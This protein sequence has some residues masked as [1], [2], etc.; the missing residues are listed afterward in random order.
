M[1]RKVDLVMF[2]APGAGKGTHAEILSK[3]YG[4]C[5]ISTGCLLRKEV[6]SGS[7]MGQKIQHIMDSGALVEDDL[8]LE[9]IGR[10]V[11]KDYNGMIFD[12]FP[13]T[14]AQ[15]KKLDELLDH[16]GRHLDVA[17]ALDV[18]QDELVRRMLER[19]TIEQRSDDNEHT[20]KRRQEEYA[21]HTL[22]VLKYY[23]DRGLLVHV[24]A[25]GDKETTQQRIAKAV[26]DAW[27]TE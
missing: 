20:F 21:E 16:H 27:P 7:E 5:H 6:A 1:K 25:G 14:V 23:A 8:V 3:K 13:R 15:A 9:M 2:G 10:E 24:D 17:V 26:N 18:E 11:D 22:P 12:G 19:A 4:F